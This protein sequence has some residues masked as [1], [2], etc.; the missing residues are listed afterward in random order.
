MQV[1][2]H[3]ACR[4][5]N[6]HESMLAVALLTL[7]LDHLALLV[8]SGVKKYFLFLKCFPLNGLRSKKKLDGRFPGGIVD[9][10]AALSTLTYR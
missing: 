9:F 7:S 6:Q 3:S 8:I 1:K 5:P 2:I 4:R 10:I